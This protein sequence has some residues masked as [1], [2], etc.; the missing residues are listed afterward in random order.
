MSTGLQRAAGISG[1]KRRKA[2]KQ[3]EKLQKELLLK[4][5]K[6]KLFVLPMAF[7]AAGVIQLN[8]SDF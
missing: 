1:Q 4:F 5:N 2:R 3:T 7:F 6:R 8:S